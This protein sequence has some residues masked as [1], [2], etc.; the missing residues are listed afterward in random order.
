MSLVNDML[1][2]LEKRGQGG[3]SPLSDD[4]VRSVSHS[5]SANRQKKRS[6]PLLIVLVALILGFALLAWQLWQ[7]RS[8]DSM[9]AQK[10]LET[11]TALAVQPSAQEDVVANRE[12]EPALLAER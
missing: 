11:R 3:Q 4:S 6:W 5:C 7:Q 8:K 12:P 1:R 2:D 9:P 10:N